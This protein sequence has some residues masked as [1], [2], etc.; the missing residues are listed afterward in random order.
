MFQ[1]QSHVRLTRGEDLLQY[2]GH[3]GRR[4]KRL[5]FGTN[6]LFEIQI[7]LVVKGGWKTQ[8]DQEKHF[9]KLKW[10]L[11][12]HSVTRSHPKEPSGSDRTQKK[13][14]NFINNVI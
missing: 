3:R 1:S 13:S 5:Q 10:F 12:F 2:G 14:Q 9:L 6:D 11:T 4:K 8:S 7:C